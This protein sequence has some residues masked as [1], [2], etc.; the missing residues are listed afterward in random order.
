MERNKEK[1]KGVRKVR[2]NERLQHN[3]LLSARK[4]ETSEPEGSSQAIAKSAKLHK[5]GTGEQAEAHDGD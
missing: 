1:G 3:K 4:T 2:R 5:R